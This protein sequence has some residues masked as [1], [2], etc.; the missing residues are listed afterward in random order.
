MLWIMG[1]RDAFI[2]IHAPARGATADCDQLVAFNLNFNP[3]SREGSDSDHVNLANTLPDFNPR[4]REGSDCNRDKAVSLSHI[5][6]HAPARGATR[7]FFKLQYDYLFQSTL[8]RGERPCSGSWACVML[9]FQ[10]TL[11]R[12]ERLCDQLPDR[13]R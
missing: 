12:G 1:V 5:S 8:P 13:W 6:I 2:S 9:L 7:R 4:S 3:R 10:S 11:P